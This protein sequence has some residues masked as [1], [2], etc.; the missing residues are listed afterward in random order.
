MRSLLNLGP[1]IWNLIPGVLK[2]LYEIYS[3]KT[4]IKK[5]N[6]MTSHVGHVSYIYLTLAFSIYF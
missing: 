2:K 5:G 3:F 6:L 4:K 1:R